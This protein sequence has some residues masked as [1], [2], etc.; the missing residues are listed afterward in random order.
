MTEAEVVERLTRDG[1]QKVQFV[2]QTQPAQDNA[3]LAVVPEGVEVISVRKL[4]DEFLERPRRKEGTAVLQTVESFIDHVQRHKDEHTAIFADRTSGNPKLVAVLDYHEKDTVAPPEGPD[5]KAKRTVGRPRFGRHQSKYAF[6]FSDEWVAWT[7]QNGKEMGQG[8]FAELLENRCVDVLDPSRAQDPV[9][10][11]VATIGCHFASPSKLMELSRGLTVRV[12]MK[13]QNQ[14]S[15]A[16]GE[17]NL[18]FATE[19]TDDKGA[20]LKVPGAFL[21]G[22]P[23]FRGGD[24]YQLVA[25][26]RYRIRDGVLKW[27]YE[28]ARSQAVYDAAFDDA[29]QLVKE[30][31][32]LDVFVGTAE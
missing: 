12:G 5:D 24:R 16:S 27:A 19:H 23:V 17:A 32:K 9:K 13:L 6:P 10:E 22:I 25:R 8:D 21:V 26:L 31:T 30:K 20:P 2:V 1:Q 7:G 4:L 28:L 29:L 14:V 15:L 11:Y 18:S 3:A